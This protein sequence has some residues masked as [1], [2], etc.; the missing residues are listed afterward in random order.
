MFKD[1]LRELVEGVDGGLAST[2]M[3]SSGIA[4]ESYAKETGD[5]AAFDISTIGIEYGVVL[6]SIK[7]A[8]EQL[9]AGEAQEVVIETEKHST[10]LRVINETYFMAFTI[11]PGANIGKARFRVRLAVPQIVADL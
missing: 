4:L 7:R 1:T 2:V 11:A 9:G 6:G 5:D 3:D 8:S 10:L